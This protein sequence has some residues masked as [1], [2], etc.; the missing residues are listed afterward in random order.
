MLP[1][2]PGNAKGNRRHAIS[3]EETTKAVHRQ[4]GQPGRA[5][6]HASLPSHPPSFVAGAGFSGLFSLSGLF[7]ST[8]E[9]NK[10]NPQAKKLAL[11]RTSHFSRVSS[12]R[13]PCL[14]QKGSPRKSWM[15]SLVENGILYGEP[16]HHSGIRLAGCGT[17]IFTRENFYGLHVW[18]NGRTL[19]QDAQKGRPARPQGVKGRGV[20]SG[21]R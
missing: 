7:S 8:N 10:T 9:R 19:P 15:I 20:P 11:S 14:P 2:R 1:D 6:P 21:V 12:I 13:D 18:H 4:N 16:V 17:T 5:N 3:L